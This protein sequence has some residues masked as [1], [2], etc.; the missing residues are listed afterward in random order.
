MK[1][2][3]IATALLFI[4][5]LINSPL[6]AGNGKKPA[7]D[8]TVCLEISG[9]VLNLNRKM[10]VPYKVELISANKV[11]DSI[12][13]NDKNEFRF[14]LNRNTH[15]A[16]RITKKGYVTRLVSIYTDIPEKN[17]SLYRFQFDTELIEKSSS[18][19]LDSDALDFPIAVISFHPELNCF[20]Y[21]EEYTADIKRQ[22]YLR[23]SF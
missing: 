3:I 15:Y 5:S 12:F 23:R 16:V 1:K 10:K 18:K 6:Y 7:S 13:I 11:I 22:L 2:T 8:T 14:N 9:R 21:N 4:A 19:K 17:L 20:Y